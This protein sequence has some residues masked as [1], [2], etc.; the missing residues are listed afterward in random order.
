MNEDICKEIRLV[1]NILKAEDLSGCGLKLDLQRSRWN[2]PRRPCKTGW[3]MFLLYIMASLWAWDG[4]WA[5]TGPC[6]GIF[7]KRHQKDA[8]NSAALRRAVGRM[9]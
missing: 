6:T 7:R 9:V 5:T 8:G 3:S 4:L 2:M 1:N